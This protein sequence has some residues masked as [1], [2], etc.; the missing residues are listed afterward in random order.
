MNLNQLVIERNGYTVLDYLSDIG[1][2]QTILISSFSLMLMVLN[3]HYAENF[4]VTKLYRLS[5]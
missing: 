2:M 5:S 4:L 1:G 3:F